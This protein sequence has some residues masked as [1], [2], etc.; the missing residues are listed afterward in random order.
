MHGIALGIGKDIVEIWLG[1]RRIPIPPSAE[2][3]L[4]SA[5]AELLNKRILKLKPF[6]SL[7]RKPK[8]IF[9][10]SSFK[11][12]DVIN[13]VWFYLRYTLPGL[14]DN[15]LV[16]NFEKLSVA[17]YMLC[18]EEIKKSEIKH[19]CDFLIDFAIEFEQIYGKGSVTM[20]L[21]ILK[22]YHEALIDCGPLWSYC[23]FGFENNI[24][25]LKN[26]VCGKTDVLEQVTKKYAAARIDINLRDEENLDDRS[27]KHVLEFQRATEIEIE[28]E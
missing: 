21:H 5:N 27:V 28:V 15:K 1:K 16:K 2:Y 11:A 19:A 6:Q 13:L 26:H 17:T 20:N 12:T 8:S 9:D 24:G 10:I 14:L 3:K 22:H 23:L 7:R 25:V 4:S 18:Q